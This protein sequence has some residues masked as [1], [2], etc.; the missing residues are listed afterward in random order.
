VL[1]ACV[2]Q[3]TTF[4]LQHMRDQA[5]LAGPG[6]PSSLERCVLPAACR[7]SLAVVAQPASTVAAAGR[8]TAEAS[9]EHGKIDADAEIA[10]CCERGKETDDWNF[11]VT[12]L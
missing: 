11:G 5:W 1:R 10:I 7:R 8:G 12:A 3:Q 9:V 2:H 4:Q 6:F